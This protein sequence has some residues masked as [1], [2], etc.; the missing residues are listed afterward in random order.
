[1]LKLSAD[2]LF[3]LAKRLTANWD[4]SFH[5]LFES[6]DKNR[7]SLLRVVT[8]KPEIPFWEASS[9]ATLIVDAIHAMSP[10]FAA[11]ATTG[12]RDAAILARTLSEIGGDNC[13]I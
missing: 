5:A 1:M 9:R 6:E 4:P 10:T 2:D 7:A 12:L 3:S 13:C 11:G 8:A